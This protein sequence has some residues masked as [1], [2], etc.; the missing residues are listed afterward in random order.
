M[1]IDTHAHLNFAAFEKDVKK[2]IQRSVENDVWMINVGTQY[3][4][5]ERA[6]E[7]ADGY[8]KGVYAAIGLHPLHL[9]E[10]KLDK[11]EVGFLP[12]FKTRS[13]EF[14]YERYK[15]LAQ[16]EKVIAVGEIGLDYYYKPKTKRKLEIFKQK[17]RE[18]LLNQLRLAQEL[19]LP[20]I[21][22]CRMAHDDLIQTIKQ[23]NNLTMRG[24]IHCFTGNWEQAEEYMN[25]GFYLGFNGIIFK[26]NLDEIIRKTPL[27]KILVETDCPYLTPSP[28]TGRNEPL[29]V[30][31]V[32]EKI[33]KIKNL[34]FEEI[35]KITTQNAK[36]SFK[37]NQ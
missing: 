24:T 30:K 25:M 5:S 12:K 28:M 29:Y 11:S 2:I 4:T 26:L 31:Y 23:F 7:I 8:K 36:K 33:A 16:S 14:D 3:N 34:S 19:D 6:V 18:A 10:Q 32:A 37:I 20:V 9:E 35:A 27:D 22:H 13:E 17:Q 21:F 15:K 1:L